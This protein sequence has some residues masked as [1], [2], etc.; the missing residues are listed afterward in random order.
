MSSIVSLPSTPHLVFQGLHAVAD[1][2]TP[3]H[4]PSERPLMSVTE[5]SVSFSPEARALN[6]GGIEII[7]AESK[8]VLLASRGSQLALDIYTRIDETT[9]EM[10]DIESEDSAEEGSTDDTDRYDVTNQVGIRAFSR[11]IYGLS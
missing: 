6:E 9:E 5:A 7:P 4:H 1:V 3:E 11:I 2:Q 8:E 10:L